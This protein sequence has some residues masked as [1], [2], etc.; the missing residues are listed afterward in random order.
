MLRSFIRIWG[1]ISCTIYINFKLLNPKQN[2]KL[3]QNILSTITTIVISII[4]VTVMYSFPNVARTLILLLLMCLFM[5]QIFHVPLR[6]S[7]TSIIISYSLSYVMFA[8]SIIQM[9][10]ISG[11]FDT[12]TGIT[13]PYILVQCLVAIIQF[14]LSF[15][16]FRIKRF[17]KVMPF[18]YNPGFNLFGI[19]MG[20]IVLACSIITEKMG[21]SYFYLIPVA[22]I[23]VSSFFF[24]IWWQ[25]HLKIIYREKSMAAEIK[26]MDNQLSEAIKKIQLLETDNINMAKVIHK[27]NKLIPAMELATQEVIKLLPS[28]DATRLS[29]ELRNLSCER[30]GILDSIE[31]SNKSI[32]S[33][34]VTYIDL[35]ISYMYKK[36]ANMDIELIF[37][38]D[39]EINHLF[40]DKSKITLSDFTTL[41]ADLTE[42][43][44]IATSSSVSKF[45]KVTIRNTSG[46]LS[47]EVY[48]SGAL[49]DKNV[50]MFFGKKQITT[51]ASESG[52]GI[53]LMNT[54]QLMEKY[55][56]SFII[57]EKID[58]TIKYTKKV[59]FIF[60]GNKRFSLRTER[61]TK[62]I[63]ELYNSR[64]DLEIK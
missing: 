34:G 41:L 8:L 55:N 52:N 27:D 39:G 44:I 18:L 40:G 35:L 1:L 22:I 5:S 29:A 53:G 15:L 6:I 49:F 61:D 31:N 24:L 4:T 3:F 10:L 48:D 62:E 2:N 42:N 50:I 16:L 17:K 12:Y 45:I 25:N 54:Y 57:D 21:T 23:V 11:F 58:D 14:I 63:I 13:L 56:A 38:T 37:C 19:Y 64:H 33:C 59:A 28:S 30:V 46:I 26:R 60:D 9:S 51:H 7:I 20:I 32:P 43:A 36:A 47:L